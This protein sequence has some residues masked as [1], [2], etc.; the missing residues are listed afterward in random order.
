MKEFWNERYAE[1]EY[2][3]GKAPNKYFKEKIDEIKPGKILFPA[4]GEG[5][6][7]IYAASKD[8][9]VSAFDISEKG[10]EKALK[11]SEEEGVHIDY[12]VGKLHAFL[13]RKF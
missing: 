10:K 5:R 13:F 8:W 6:N 9:E 4:E 11:L 2:V 3:Y 12:K 7:A 1:K